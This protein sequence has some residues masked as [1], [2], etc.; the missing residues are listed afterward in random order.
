[1]NLRQ[2]YRKILRQWTSWI[3]VILFCLIITPHLYG[4]VAQSSRLE[5]ELED[6]DQPFI[7]VGNDNLGLSIFRMAR[8]SLESVG[9]KFVEVIKI[10][11]SLNVVWSNFYQVDKDYQLQAYDYRDEYLYLL[12]Q[13][14]PVLT[15]GLFLLTVDMIDGDTLH[16]HIPSAIPMDMP[17]IKALKDAVLVFGKYNYKDAILHYDLFS[18]QIKALPGFY[19]N[20]SEL[21]HINAD[22]VINTFDILT[23]EKYRQRQTTLNIA[24]FDMDGNQ[25]G[26]VQLIPENDLS[27]IQGRIINNYGQEKIVAGTF[28]HKRSIFSRGIFMATINEEGESDIK[29][30]NFADLENFFGYLKPRRERRTKERIARRKEQG[31]DTRFNYR[32]LVHEIIPHGDNFILLGEAF[33]PKYNNMATDPYFGGMGTF[34][35][36][37]PT[38][39]FEGYRYTHAVLV[40]FDENGKLAWDNSFE[41]N[42]VTSFNLQ[43]FVH[44]VPVGNRQALLYLFE[45]KIHSKLI[46]NDQVV[47]GKTISDI[48]LV[49]EEDQLRSSESDISGLLR[50]YDQYF[51]AFGVQRIKNLSDSNVKLNRRIFYINKVF[52]QPDPELTKKD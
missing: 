37:N 26:A 47:E 25:I 23:T 7:P 17:D 49:Y 6:R 39:Y 41:I 4:Q 1:M 14:S 52:Y 2:T 36:Q 21:M 5:F 51:F 40:A 27:L 42:D 13:K 3:G 38:Y 43:Q 8:P 12:F 9:A 44:A 29:Y 48:Q 15:K 35:G 50:W 24:T 46:Q 32:L 33:Y 28:A 10:D 22:E 20:N 16:H 11:T 34:R 31:K 45:N 30:Y 18:G 19:K